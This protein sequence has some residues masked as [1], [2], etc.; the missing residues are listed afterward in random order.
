ML[1]RLLNSLGSQVGVLLGCLLES[2]LEYLLE[3][4]LESLLDCLV[5]GL[6]ER[7]APTQTW[8]YRFQMVIHHPVKSTSLARFPLRRDQ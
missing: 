5:A 2:L 3:S 1:K 7:V 6:L 4:L 8:P